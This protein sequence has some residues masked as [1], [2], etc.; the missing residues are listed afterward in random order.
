MDQPDQ[1]NLNEL[2][3]YGRTRQLRRL[4]RLIKGALQLA[5][6][7]APRQFTLNACFQL[8]GAVALAGQVLVSQRLIAEL[9]DLGNGT[10]FASVVPWLIGIATLSSVVAFTGLARVEQQYVMGDLVA[11]HAIG[12]VLE[13]ATAVDL[14]TFDSPQFHNRLLRA[15]VNAS[16]RPYQMATGV[17]TMMSALVTMGGIGVALLLIEPIFLAALL[18]AYVPAWVA[19]AKASKASYQ[20]S[21]AQTERDRRRSYLADVLSKREGAAEV[22]AFGLTSFLRDRHDALY[23]TRI[24][25]LKAMAARRL[26]FGLLGALATAFLNA[27][28]LAL[29]VWFISSGRLDLAEAGAAA[30]AILLFAQRLGAL[31]GGATSL[32]ESSLFIEDFTSFVEAMPALEQARPTGDAPAGV[33]LIEVD[34]VSFSYPNRAEPVLVDVSIEVRRGEVVA[35][36]GENGSGK[37]TLAKLLAGLYAP[38]SGAIRWDGVDL[39]TVDRAQVSSNVGVI[40]QDYVRYLLSARENIGFGRHERLSDEVALREA[41]LRASADGFLEKLPEG[42]DTQL[43]TEYWGGSDLSGGQWQRV[44]LARAFFRD[45]PLLIL[46]EPTASLDPRSEADL[47]DRIHELY[48]GRTVLLIS[49]RFSTVR[50]AD[51]IFV[52]EQGRVV[53]QGNHEQLMARRGLYAE[54]FTLQANAYADPSPEV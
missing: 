7:A 24:V 26:R 11:R 19:T 45:A 32:Y 33:D 49:H 3:L 8:L 12:Q 39:S 22:R 54:L 21:V 42:Y 48:Q 47:F 10:E 28:A 35:L 6:Q 14:I 18:V 1:I 34:H 15:Q 29:L 27:G 16:S 36:V 31:A 25:E 23:E 50:A 2:F 52:L 17:L 38:S 5:W 13:V 44:A 41:A 43:G 46:D 53:E 51:R 4:P 37:T 30:T 20:F 9:L 40:F